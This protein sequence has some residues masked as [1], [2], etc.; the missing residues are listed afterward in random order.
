MGLS[1]LG[2]VILTADF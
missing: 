1:Y 2:M